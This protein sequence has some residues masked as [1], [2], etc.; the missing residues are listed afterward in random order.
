MKKSIAVLFSVLYFAAACAP[1]HADPAP[2]PQ[3]QDPVKQQNEVPPGTLT[4]TIDGNPSDWDT[5]PFLAQDKPE[6]AEDSAADVFAIKAIQD[7]NNLYLMLAFDELQTENF[8]VSLDLPAM[9][10]RKVNLEFFPVS[11]DP[12]RLGLFSGNGQFL[13]NLP[14]PASGSSALGTAVEYRIA[15]AELHEIAPGLA[16]PLQIKAANIRTYDCGDPNGCSADDIKLESQV[17]VSQDIIQTGGGD[18]LQLCNPGWENLSPAS[19][20]DANDTI[21]VPAGYSA[22]WLVAPIGF[23]MPIEIIN[24]NDE[25]YFVLSSREGMIYSLDLQGNIAPVYNVVNGTTADIDQN[26]HIFL[27]DYV[28]GAVDDIGPDG[29]TRRIVESRDLEWDGTNKMILGDDGMLYF[30][31]DTCVY[32]LS[33]GGEYEC[34]AQPAQKFFQFYR[35]R[36]G[37]LIGMGWN[38]GFLVSATDFSSR[39][40]F[41]LPNMEGLT[42]NAL[43]SDDSGNL[44]VAVGRQIFKVDSNYQVSLLA[45]L[46]TEGLSGVEWVKETNEI[47]GGEHRNGGVVAVDAE[48]GAVRRLVEGNGLISPIALAVSA[49]SEIA[50]SNDDGNNVT[51]V[52][53]DASTHYWFNYLSYTPPTPHLLTTADNRL[54]V[55]EDEVGN[56]GRHQLHIIP[57][58]GLP[59]HSKLSAGLEDMTACGLAMDTQGEIFYT[60]PFDGTLNRLNDNQREV[61]AE[62][63]SFPQALSPAPQGGFY[64]L[65]GGQ[66]INALMPAPFSAGELYYIS[67]E[68][69]RVKLADQGG[70]DL[71][72]SPENDLYVTDGDSV[73]Q[74]DPVGE[75]TQFASGFLSPGGIVFDFEGAMI[76][77]DIDRNALVRISGFPSGTIQAAI[78]DANDSPVSSAEVRIFRTFPELAGRRM[79]TDSSGSFTLA[80]APGSYS[81]SILIDGSQ[82]M[83][84]EGV[85]VSAGQTTTLDLKVS[86]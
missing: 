63:F 51:L 34:I 24:A 9:D 30:Y 53:P 46:E 48:T 57:A 83:L 6:D 4:L 10:D 12:G 13:E 33:K 35:A 86:Q 17:P 36:D 15:L 81:V 28:R 79:L 39:Q 50:V 37:R 16:S 73:F 38:S 62:G 68:G 52:A 47:I 20:P 58:E 42:Y 85:S 3:Q 7:A 27:Y 60:H 23:N 45:R 1:S 71:I 8:L 64:L 65:A 5:V 26:Q 75:R 80:T 21:E 41:T 18:W 31:M 40:V 72:L 70:M 43:T 44:Y 77:S 67:A 14:S 69:E 54:F 59:A 84:Q 25:Q 11:Q 22:Q 56:Q 55:A 32:R 19:L 78:H 2:Q 29:S 49:C 66:P 74:I 61:I 76:I 82:V